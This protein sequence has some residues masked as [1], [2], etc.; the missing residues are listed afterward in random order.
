MGHSHIESFA[1]PVLTSFRH[2]CRF[3]QSCILVG[4]RFRFQLEH[5]SVTVSEFELMSWRD[6]GHELGHTLG[7][8]EGQRG[9]MCCR[10]WGQ[11]ESYMTGW[12][13]NNNTP[14][15][16]NLWSES[17]TE[18]RGAQHHT[19]PW[20]T[21]RPA[22]PQSSVCPATTEAHPLLANTH[23]TTHWAWFQ[24][25]LNN[26]TYSMEFNHFKLKY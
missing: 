24:E 7:D 12:L 25:S 8:G 19:T 10:P 14:K 3:R 11:K 13:N 21:R 23:D 15:G 4:A 18:L 1:F 22:H 17:I 16:H 2:H 6:N 26:C 5:M 20:S 9:L